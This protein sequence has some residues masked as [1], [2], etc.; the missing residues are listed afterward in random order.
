MKEDRTRQNSKISK[1]NS[2]P[3]ETVSVQIHP[4]SDFTVGLQLVSELLRERGFRE[5]SCTLKM[6]GLRLSDELDRRM[7]SYSL[8]AREQDIVCLLVEGLTNKEIALRSYITEQTV[9]DHLKHVY[10]K[11]GVHQRSAV[12]ARLLSSE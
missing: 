4:D 8:S 3:F 11:I 10:S 9:K 5:L 1:T 2:G 7:R 6:E 12:L